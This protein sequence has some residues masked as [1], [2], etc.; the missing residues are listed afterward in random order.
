[1][2]ED[3]IKSKIR[4]T[5]ITREN[6]LD[7]RTVVENVSTEKKQKVNPISSNDRK[8]KF[9]SVDYTEEQISV[10]RK[11]SPFYIILGVLLLIGIVYLIGKS[12]Q[13]EY[14]EMNGEVWDT[15]PPIDTTVIDTDT[16]ASEANYMK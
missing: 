9:K 3:V 10:K 2:K 12:N 11:L 1:M 13:R 7:E 15:I 4:S 6:E 14:I 8:E 5:K 16:T